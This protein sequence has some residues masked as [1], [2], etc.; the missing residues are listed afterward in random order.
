MYT[1][2]TA[3]RAASSLLMPV[4]RI[5]ACWHYEKV[6]HACASSRRMNWRNPHYSQ[7]F[8]IRRAAFAQTCLTSG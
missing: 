1:M 4:V 2:H 3:E 7:D 8:V 5:L 6:A